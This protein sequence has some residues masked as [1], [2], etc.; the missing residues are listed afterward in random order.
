MVIDVTINIRY[1]SVS[2]FPP[3]FQQACNEWASTTHSQWVEV[4]KSTWENI[5]IYFITEE[6]DA[7]FS[8]NFL[9]QSES[10]DLW[11]HEPYAYYLGTVLHKVCDI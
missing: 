4:K 3:F 10:F 7:K 2:L 1:F 11:L 6:K 9:S 5:Y 8:I